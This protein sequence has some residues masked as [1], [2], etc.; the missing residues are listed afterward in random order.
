MKEEHRELMAM[1]LTIFSTLLLIAFIAYDSRRTAGTPIPTIIAQTTVTQ[2]KPEVRPSNKIR[3]F[4]SER[5]RFLVE[6][7]SSETVVEL[8]NIEQISFVL[9]LAKEIGRDVI[10]VKEYTTICGCSAHTST[11]IT[12]KAEPKTK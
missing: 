3:E 7:S 8:D 9:N 2:P 11:Y 1:L 4:D 12:L 10:S 6:Q 5:L